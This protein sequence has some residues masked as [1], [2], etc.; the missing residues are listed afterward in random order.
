MQPETHPSGHAGRELADTL[1]AL[2]L[3]DTVIIALSPQNVGLAFDVA[4][5]LGCELDLLLVGRI[6]AP[7]HPE[8]T[9]GSVIDLDEPQTVIDEDL[10]REFHV[11]PGYL[12]TERQ[13]Q[14]SD[15]ERR[16][17]MYLGDGDGPCHDHAGKDVVIVDDGVEAAILQLVL[18]RLGTSGAQSVRVVRIASNDEPIDDRAIAQLLKQARRFHKLLH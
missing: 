2:S 14:L 3:A 8:T 1:S 15:L 6:H 4:Q 13:R 12:N 7:G 5:R 10:A 18:Q 17:F 16:H 9:I 11:P